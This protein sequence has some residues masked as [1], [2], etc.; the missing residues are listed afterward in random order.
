[1]KLGSVDPGLLPPAQSGVKGPRPPPPFRGGVP[2]FS[3]EAVRWVAGLNQGAC[4]RRSSSPAV[5]TIAAAKNI[6]MIRSLSVS[7]AR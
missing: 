7:R 3:D 5:I 6:A 2:R 1:M 4:H